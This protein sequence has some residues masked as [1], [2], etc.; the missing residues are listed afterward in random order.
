MKII[1]TTEVHNTLR[2][3][4]FD[5]RVETGACLFGTKTDIGEFKVLHLAGPGKNAKHYACHYEGDNDHYEEVYN[6]LLKTV[7][8]LKHIGEFHVHPA[9]MN[10]LSFGDRRTIKKVLKTYEEFVAGVILRELDWIDPCDRTPW[11]KGSA[12][13]L[14]PLKCV[15]NIYPVYFSRTKPKGEKLELVIE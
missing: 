8:D 9:G 7:P 6:A 5:T 2:E 4:A 11:L 15:M 3:I 13:R 1:L 10:Q 14:L 12:G